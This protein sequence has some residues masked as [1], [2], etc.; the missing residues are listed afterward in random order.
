[1]KAWQ[2]ITVIGST[3]PTWQLRDGR[4]RDRATIW[5]TSDGKFTWHTWDENGTGGENWTQGTLEDAK[6]HAVAS[7]VLQ[8]WAPGGWRVEWNREAGA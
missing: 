3:R 6:R 1:M 7:L 5:Q 8:G 2:W 4:G